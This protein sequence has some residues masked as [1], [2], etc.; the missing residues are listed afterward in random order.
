MV[1]VDILQSINHFSIR[2]CFR[3]DQQLNDELLTLTISQDEFGIWKSHHYNS[4][5]WAFS[6]I[7]IVIM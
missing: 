6:R 4:L 3:I 5:Q 1:V 2:I 7:I